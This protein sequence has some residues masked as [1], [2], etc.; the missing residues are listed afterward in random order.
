MK[1]ECPEC[2]QRLSA[3]AAAV[4]TMVR[5]PSC[6]H[7]IEIPSPIAEEDAAPASVEKKGT[8]AAAKTKP[9]AERKAW[10]ETDPTNPNFF[11]GLGIG[12]VLLV[13]WLGLLYPFNPPPEKP[14]ADYNT[15]QFV[16]SLF[17]KHFVASFLNTLFFSWAMAIIYLKLRIIRHQ[18]AALLLDVLPT[19]LGR[20]IG[21]E[22]VGAFIEHVYTLPV[23][24]RD[25]LMVNRIRKALELFEIR[26]NVGDVR[27]MMAI[28]SEIDSARIGGSYSLLRAFLWGIPLVGFIGTVVGLSHAIGGMSFANVEDVSKIVS[29]INNVTSGLGTAF[30]ATLLG[31]VLALTLNF[32]LNALAKQEDD[33][34]HSIDA[35]CN[36]VL[37]P[38]LK[39]SASS[40]TD[41]AAIAEAVVRSIAHTQERFLADLNQL[42]ARMN[43]YSA[44]LDARLAEHQKTV[45]DEFVAKTAELRAQHQLALKEAGEQIV[46]FQQS[47]GTAAGARNEELRA[48]TDKAVTESLDRVAHYLSG[49]ES[50][51]GSLNKVLKDLGEKQITVSAPQKRR[52]WFGRA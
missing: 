21:V 20:E 35:F 44:N 3:P 2:H 1:F 17:F 32:P 10:K 16:A 48:Q 23:R 6:D 30:D 45:T 11:K 27:E 31:L 29:S 47:L 19:Q 7:R 40:L 52:G 18:K 39:E 8:T 46:K 5:C 38:R 51:I 33:N 22:N 4:G 36:E 50:G 12:F 34:L 37:L 13:L 24:L 15:M 14:I 49:L 41:T 42:A 26:Q 43:D 25:S 9:K 28:Q